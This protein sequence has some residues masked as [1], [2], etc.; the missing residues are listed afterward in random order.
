MK[1]LSYLT[2]ILSGVFFAFAMD[3]VIQGD[4]GGII[5]KRAFMGVVFGATGIYM[6]RRLKKKSQK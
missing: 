1:F 4:A 6:Y 2:I 5:F 3:S